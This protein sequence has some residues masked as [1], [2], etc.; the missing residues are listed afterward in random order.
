MTAISLEAIKQRLA[1]MEDAEIIDR[2]TT[3]GLRLTFVYLGTL[4][5][6]ERLNESILEPLVRSF[7]SSVKKSLT[8]AR[9]TRLSN[10]EQALQYLMKGSVLVHDSSSG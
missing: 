6:Q 2:E 3:D 5:D 9:I 7:Q 4:I 10:L 1:L 8:T